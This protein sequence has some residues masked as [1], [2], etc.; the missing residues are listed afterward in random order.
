MFG[1]SNVGLRVGGAGSGLQLLD[2]V[3]DET[4]CRKV[5]SDDYCVKWCVLFDRA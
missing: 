2:Y 1:V 3:L 5:G 4:V